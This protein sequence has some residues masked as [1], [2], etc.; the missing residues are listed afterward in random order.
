MAVA[1]A[2]AP[3]A[4][5]GG[6]SEGRD[7]CCRCGCC[8]CCCGCCCSCRVAMISGGGCSWERWAWCWPVAC[9][10]TATAGAGGAGMP[11]SAMPL[12]LP[13]A[14]LALLVLPVAGPRTVP[15]PC[16]INRPIDPSFFFVVG[17]ILN[18]IDTED[19]V[20]SDAAT[21]SETTGG[22][23]WHAVCGNVR[24]GFVYLFTCR[25][26]RTG[27]DGRGAEGGRGTLRTG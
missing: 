20:A 11:I 4:A 7:C 15:S 5:V 9:R 26:D 10:E 25:Q 14:A 23:G 27:G 8:G 24:P 18:R 1:V 19:G 13:P 2:M 22:D 17:I 3:A 21:W 6:L 16:R 12:P